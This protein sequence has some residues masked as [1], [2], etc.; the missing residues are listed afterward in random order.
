MVG[1]KK[2]YSIHFLRFFA[3]LAVVAH[4][5]VSRYEPRLMVGA[6]GVDIFF[7]ISGLVIG[8]AMLSDESAGAFATRR[9]IRIYPIYWI[10]TLA[11]V[12]FRMW[13]WA[14]HP[15]AEELAGSLVILPVYGAS[16]H[17][18]YWPAWTLEYEVSFYALAAL[19]MVTFRSKAFV[20]CFVSLVAI[21]LLRIPIPDTQPM[22][23]FVLDRFIEFAVGLMISYFIIQKYLIN[24]AIGA[25]LVATAL[26]IFYLTRSPGLGPAIP[27]KYPASML[28]IGLL[29]F[30]GSSFF[31]NTLFKLGG[32][33]SYSIY[34]FHVLA[35]EL[36]FNVSY[37]FGLDANAFRPLAATTYSA[38][39]VVFALIIGMVA[40]LCIER[41]ILRILRR[42][43]LPHGHL[44]HRLT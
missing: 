28:V 30:E 13:I 41:P 39:C 4:H 9:L 44:K 32:D 20:A 37:K 23:Y 19:L 18:I 16:W 31:R 3:S 42:R 43:L 35:I 24:K 10:A 12:L 29:A 26:I 21:S 7:V 25:V 38:F 33:A 40:H 2:L 14:E 6:A 22:Q 11:Y 36:V 17:P 27:W 34:L 8:M 1:D 5:V 15:S